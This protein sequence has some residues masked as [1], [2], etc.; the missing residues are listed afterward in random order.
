MILLSFLGT[1]NYTSTIYEWQGKS[2]ETAYSCAAC[3]EFLKP[4]RILVF[5][6]REASEKNLAGLREE[7]RKTGIDVEPIEIPVGKNESELWQI[8]DILTSQLAEKTEIAFDVTNGQ[9]SLPLVALLATVFM[10]TGLEV[11]ILHMFYGALN[12]DPQEAPGHSPIFDLTPM[13]Q[14]LDWSSAADRFNRSGDSADMA[15]LLEDFGR[16]VMGNNIGNVKEQN[17]GSDFQKLGGALTEITQDYLLLRPEGVKDSVT[18]LKKMIEKN[19]PAI[20]EYP[21]IKPLELLLERIQKTYLPYAEDEKIK[22]TEDKDLHLLQKEKEMIVWYMEHG[23][24]MQALSLS[25]EWLVT[26]IMLWLD[27]DPIM[28]EDTRDNV[29]RSINRF[30]RRSNYGK[31]R[32]TPGLFNQVDDQTRNEKNEL[33]IITTEMMEKFIDV[34]TFT[35]LWGSLADIRNDIDH[36]G[37]RKKPKTAKKLISQSRIQIDQLCRLPMPKSTNAGGKC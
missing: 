37:H 24:I 27:F 12:I 15:K 11:K 19:L 28:D 7:I 9:R 5:L 1:N 23:H 22:R 21:D 20:H 16:D 17:K 14:L 13:L 31:I 36:A 29:S 18:Q 32:V 34:K 26:W 33:P 8:F 3:A 2:C 6:T 10:K 30:K 4:E 25:R 35:T